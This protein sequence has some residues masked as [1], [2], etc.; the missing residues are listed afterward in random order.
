MRSFSKINPRESLRIYSIGTKSDKCCSLFML[1]MSHHFSVNAQLSIW[2]SN[3]A[4]GLRNNYYPTAMYAIIEG[5]GEIAQTHSLALSCADYLR[6]Q[7]LISS[8][9]DEISTVLAYIVLEV[10]A[11]F[12][13]STNM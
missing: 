4:S 11:I 1:Y 13:P 2:A 10:N 8:E 6:D 12:P 5:S 7:C 9:V 3:E